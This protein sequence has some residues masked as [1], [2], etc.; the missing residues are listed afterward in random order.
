MIFLALGN[1]FD[2]LTIVGPFD[3][4][5]DAIAYAEGFCKNETWAIIN[6][7]EP[8]SEFCP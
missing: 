8:D 6:T 2:G 4:N 1:P 7:L 5:E 3:W